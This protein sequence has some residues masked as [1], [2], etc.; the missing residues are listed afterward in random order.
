MMS[1]A[2]A[3]II[4][5]KNA[6]FDGEDFNYGAIERTSE[7][8]V[9][10]LTGKS[11]KLLRPRHETA[12]SLF[13][14]SSS[15]AKRKKTA[16]RL[17]GDAAEEA[18]SGRR[19]LESSQIIVATPAWILKLTKSDYIVADRLQVSFRVLL[20]IWFQIFYDLNIMIINEVRFILIC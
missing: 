4:P 14:K 12:K 3:W 5:P 20:F 15:E 11:K 13:G 17:S 8:N 6:K 9:S 18:E 16:K 2:A 1:K 7:I 10:V 19:A